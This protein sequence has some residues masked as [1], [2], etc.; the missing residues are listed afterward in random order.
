MLRVIF[1][2]HNGDK[3]NLIFTEGSLGTYEETGCI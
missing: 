1:D 3:N 2:M